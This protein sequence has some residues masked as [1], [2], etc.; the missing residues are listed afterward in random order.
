MVDGKLVIFTKRQ[1][2]FDMIESA[3]IFPYCFGD[4]LEEIARNEIICVYKK[5]VFT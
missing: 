3:G 4:F 2:V 1:D 5:D